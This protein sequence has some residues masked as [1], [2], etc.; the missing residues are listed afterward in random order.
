MLGLVARLELLV[1]VIPPTVGRG[2]AV[3]EV[4]GDVRPPGGV[5]P[6]EPHSPTLG[7]A[8]VDRTNGPDVLHRHRAGKED[9]AVGSEYRRR[10]YPGAAAQ[11]LEGMR[12]SSTARAENCSPSPPGGEMAPQQFGAPPPRGSAQLKEMPAATAE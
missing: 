3:P 2:M 5:A 1:T 11:L 6:P 4:V 8:R 7:R 9:D 12:V 10:S